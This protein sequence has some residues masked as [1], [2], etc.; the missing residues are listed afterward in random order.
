[1]TVYM[2]SWVGSFASQADWQLVPFH[3]SM[4]HHERD[5]WEFH[6][7]G[8]R[9]GGLLLVSG[10]VGAALFYHLT[11]PP[12]QLSYTSLLLA[13]GGFVTISGCISNLS[14]YFQ[15]SSGN[16]KWW[17]ESFYVPSFASLFLFGAGCALSTLLFWSG[18][19]HAALMLA[20]YSLLAASVVALASGAI[21]FLSSWLLASMVANYCVK[22]DGRCNL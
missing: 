18:Q 4:M 8:F 3:G 20:T 2:G 11:T 12:H 10:A 9:F 21:G 15:F 6:K 16:T 14:A 17:W 7:L 1:M 5:S 13:F 19:G 22:M